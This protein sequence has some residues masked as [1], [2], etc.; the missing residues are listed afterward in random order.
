MNRRGLTLIVAL[1]LSLP[2]TAGL[3]FIQH[4]DEEYSRWIEVYGAS[5]ALLASRCVEQR[6]AATCA[7]ADKRST[8]VAELI[9][10]RNSVTAW[11]WPALAATLLAWGAVL[12]SCIALLRERLRLR[13]R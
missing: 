7:A 10:Y 8:M 1:V 11:W 4:T 12:A 13:K 6:S 3:R 5:A 2:P 9:D